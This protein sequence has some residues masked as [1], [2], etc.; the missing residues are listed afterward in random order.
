MRSGPPR[1]AGQRRQSQPDPGTVNT[2]I[3]WSKVWTKT[4]SCPSPSRSPT[5]GAAGAP[6]PFPLWPGLG[7]GD[8][9]EQRAV[10]GQHDQPARVVDVRG[11]VRREQ[12]LGGAVL[13]QVGHRDL[14]GVHHG[15]AVPVIEPPDL[16][17][18]GAEGVD[19]AVVQRHDDLRPGVALDVDGGRRRDAP[20]GYHPSTVMGAPPRGRVSQPALRMADRLPSPCAPSSTMTA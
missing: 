11:A 14:G 16:L 12:Q 20:G 7:S 9:V 5:V 10:R 2:S 6:F 1:P 3:P 19:V 18:V 13:V 4:S 15:L 17:R 8:V